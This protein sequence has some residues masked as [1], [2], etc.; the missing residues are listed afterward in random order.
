MT[1]LSVLHVIPSVSVLD[2]GPS[3]AIRLMERGLTQ[4]G[5]TVTTLTTRSPIGA[6][7]QSSD[8]EPTNRCSTRVYKPRWSQFYKIAPGLLPYLLN[9]LHSF[10]VVHIHALFS[11]APTIAAWAAR[12]CGIPYIVRPLGTLNHYG[13]TTRRARLKQL[14]VNV[15]ERRILSEAAAIHFTSPAEQE[16]AQQLGLAYRGIVIPL[17]IDAMPANALQADQL[18]F[19]YPQLAGRRVILF[20][21]R[22]DPKKNIEALI[23][24]LA[25]SEFLK[26]RTVLLVAGTG[27]PSYMAALKARAVAAGVAH[28]V[29]W[30]GHIEANEKAD[31]LA[32][33]DVFVLPSYSENFGIAVAEALQAGIPC[34]VGKGIA[35][36][37]EIE[38]NQAGLAVEPT[39]ADIARALERVLSNEPMRR[40]MSAHARS[41]AAREYSLD[42]M[43]RRL[44]TLYETVC[45]TRRG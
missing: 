44:I 2:G 20:L 5:L 24:A 18:K 31:A 21:S 42:T 32:A 40:E 7:A 26:S 9:N 38:N 22:I 36:A 1:A 19:H 41:L 33:A 8:S 43:T 14:S 45:K 6:C 13:M 11:F 27:V 17:G 25:C 30:C 35:I 3:V 10:D 29:A 34:I 28:I 12:H 4:A 37:D 16:Q 23:D 15:I 39:A